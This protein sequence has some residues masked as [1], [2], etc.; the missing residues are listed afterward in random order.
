MSEVRRE[1]GTARYDSSYCADGAELLPKFGGD[2]VGA[3]QEAARRHG[4]KPS[5]AGTTA[6]AKPGALTPG[7]G[8]K[9]WCEVFREL[10]IATVSGGENPAAGAGALPWAEINRRI[11]AE[12]GAC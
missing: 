11:A 3:L 2:R 8:A 12:N 10:N 7:R 5:D 4:V 1:N 6:P 9:P